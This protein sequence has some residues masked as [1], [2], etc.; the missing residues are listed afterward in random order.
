MI[1]TKWL[2]ETNVSDIKL[3]GGKCS[4]LGEMISNLQHLNIKIPNGFV[5]TSLAFDYFME[6][7]KLFEQIDNIIN[8]TNI[9]DNVD[10]KRN[11]Q[12]IRNLIING[13]FSEDL[14]KEILVMYKELSNN[15][16][17]NL[18]NIQNYT[19]VAVR[20]SGISEDMPDASFAGQQDTYLNVRGNSVLL[21]KIKCCFASLYNDRAISYRKSMNYDNHNIKIAVCVQKMIRS[22]LGSSGVAFSLDTESGNKNVILINGS[23]GLGEMI[24]GGQIKPDEFIVF[25]PTLEQGYKAI[26]DKKLGDKTHKMVYSDDADK[27]TKIIAVENYKKNKFCLDDIKL[28]QLSKWVCDIENYYSK[29][30]GRWVGID[31][32]WALDGLTNEL[33]IVQARPETIHSRKK[34][35]E[36]CEYSVDAN[37]NKKILVSGIAVGSKMAKGNV[38]IMYTLDT[39]DNQLEF[40][41]GDIL[42]T[43]ITD[44]DWEPIMKKASAII[45][46][47]GGKTSHAAI[48]CRELGIPAIVGT[49]NCTEVLKNNQEITLSCAE[50]E[51]GYVYDSFLNF[52]VK[53]TKINELPKTKTKVMLNIASPELAFTQSMLSHSGV[54]LARLEF[55]I[56]NYIQVHPNALIN[57]DKIKDQQLKNKI[58][59]LI[60]G[61]EN[62]K[63]YY[64]QKLAYGI[65]KIAA[66]F[67]P[68]D[69]IVRTSD[70]KSNEYA[71]LLGGKEYEPTEENPLI[72]YRGAS[73]Y[74]SQQFR[75]A[76]GLE[77]DALKYVRDVM[78]LRNVVIMLPFVRSVEECKK[79]LEVMKEY[80]LERGKNGLKI[81]LMCEIP[82][83]VILVDEFS[84]YVDGYSIGSNDLTMLTLGADRDSELIS[85]IYDERNDAVKKVISMAIKGCQRNEIKVGL[86]GNSISCYP[87]FANFLIQEGIDSVSV[88]ADCFIQTVQNIYEFENKINNI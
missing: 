3:T 25:K 55:I 65:G 21:D 52:N 10:L 27:R 40:N 39:R 44:P 60:L 45:T 22:D 81:F 74:Y 70:F 57:Y 49:G 8:I 9:D 46:N 69:V 23:W 20:S 85:H 67:Y 59:Q 29:L 68:Y 11:S 78:G 73:R 32:E 17:D 83:N 38:K 35:Y 47:K 4:S 30:H 72:G 5:V 1:Y 71:N 19:D 36:I 84:K 66:A 62:P 51:V 2:N 53:R 77:C 87:E 54:G 75:D 58:D 48:I 28:L 63:A 26:I 61:Y 88:T 15:Y 76:F 41:E 34:E 14:K 12:K 18:G 64:V 16:C 56:N 86:C 42:T 43:D 82:S 80:G 50:G 79:V 6:Q 33:Y 13:E 37:Q 7:N 31:T 24:V